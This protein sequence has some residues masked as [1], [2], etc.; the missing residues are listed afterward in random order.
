MDLANA[1]DERLVAAKAP[2]VAGDAFAEFYRRYERPIL[3]Y[4]VR[5]NADAELAADLTANAFLD[6]LR[7]RYRFRDRGAGSAA[8]WLYGVA[9]YV[10]HRHLRT[11]AAVARRDAKLQREHRSLTDHQAREIEA[12]THDAPLL[13]ALADLPATQ[14]DA[15]FAYVVAEDDYDEMAER[16]GIAPATARKRV[17][18]GLAALRSAHKEAS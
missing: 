6:A 13:A 2:S 18:R 3:A 8:A 11:S 14:R 16:F 9:Q 7:A 15:V 17:S 1:T 4:F 12:L 5:R 10:Q